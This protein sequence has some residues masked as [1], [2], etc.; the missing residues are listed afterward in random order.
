MLT[1]THSNESTHSLRYLNFEKEPSDLPD[2]FAVE[3]AHAETCTESSVLSEAS[4]KRE[5][6][7]DVQTNK[8]VPK[9]IAEPPKDEGTQ[10]AEPSAPSVEVKQG[11][12]RRLDRKQSANG[13]DN[14]FENGFENEEAA[15]SNADPNDELNENEVTEGFG[16][17]EESDDSST[18]EPPLPL[19]VVAE[20]AAV[21]ESG[22]P[23]L[24]PQTP[25]TGDAPSASSEN[26]DGGQ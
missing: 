14:G 24:M 2:G 16:E 23:P 5:A 8:E 12:I 11:G 4:K 7:A 15:E 1:C 21:A 18:V 20:S 22:P 26:D 13:F 10:A 6:A 19:E 25:P 17:A 3:I 9:D